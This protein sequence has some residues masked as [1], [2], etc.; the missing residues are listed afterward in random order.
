MVSEGGQVMVV[1]TDLWG[2]CGMGVQDSPTPGE[3]SV[4]PFDCLFEWGAARKYFNFASLCVSGPVL[5]FPPTPKHPLGKN[6]MTFSLCQVM[7]V[8]KRNLRVLS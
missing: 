3:G 6:D 2:G 4:A 7:G 8:Y 5:V 1:E